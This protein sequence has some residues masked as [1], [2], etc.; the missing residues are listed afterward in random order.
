MAEDYVWAFTFNVVINSAL[1]FLTLTL[2]CLGLI[3]LFRIKRPRM[4]A[5]FLCLPVIKMAVDPWLY[6]FSKWALLHQVNP[7]TAEEGTRAISVT[8][9]L[10]TA[11]GILPLTTGVQ[12]FVNDGMTFTLADFIIHSLDPVLIKIVAAIAGGLSMI[13]FGLWMASLVRA[14]TTLK[15]IVEGSRPCRRDIVNGL[16][17]RKFRRTKAVILVSSDI[18]MPCA[19][20]VFRKAICLPSAIMESLTQKEFEAIIAHEMNHLEWHDGSV[21]VILRGISLLFW[22]IPSGWLLKKIAH[23]QELACDDMVGRFDISPSDLASAILKAIKAVRSSDPRIPALMTNFVHARSEV[24]RI[25]RLAEN[26]SGA[27]VSWRLWMQ[28]GAVGLCMLIIIFGRFW[29]F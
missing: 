11:S 5:V 7:L 29:I 16:L 20:G 1:S 2:V 24:E 6:D 12:L 22:W 9:C 25:R 8:L 15:N 17:L 26:R 14:R 18:A 19:F 27:R 21:R 4:I 23:Y 28:A 3:F 10:P 13:F